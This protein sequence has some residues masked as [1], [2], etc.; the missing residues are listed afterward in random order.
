MKK[1]K[2]PKKK[3]LLPKKKTF[4]KKIVDIASEVEVAQYQVEY[5]SLDKIKLWGKN[6]RLNDKGAQKLARLIEK[7]KKFVDPIVVDQDGFIRAGNT[8]YKAARILKLPK[9]P[10]VRVHWENEGDAIMYAISN[11]KAHEFTGWDA[12]ELASAFEHKEV[13]GFDLSGMSG[14]S[15]KELRG[16]SWEGDEDFIGAIEEKRRE[17]FGVVR[18]KCPKDDTEVIRSKIFEFVETLKDERLEVL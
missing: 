13:M 6:P 11:N 14:F 5:V 10:I 16:L 1:S 18:V 12:D 4:K 17:Q 8:R 3:K 15:D 7:N 2:L 9:V